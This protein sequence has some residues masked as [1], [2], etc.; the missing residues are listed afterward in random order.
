LTKQKLSFKEVP[1]FLILI[2][3]YPYFITLIYSQSYFKEMIG[4]GGEWLRVSI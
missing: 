1:V 2:F 3:I 4:V